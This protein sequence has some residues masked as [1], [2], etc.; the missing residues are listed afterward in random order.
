ME[1]LRAR[2]AAAPGKNLRL[3]LKRSDATHNTIGRER[4]TGTEMVCYFVE[5]YD[6][7][8]A[9]AAKDL[10]EST[11][12]REYVASMFTLALAML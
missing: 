12:V 5:R 6:V 3:L 11:K 4:K 2:N 1:K 9:S 10:D 8:I 7:V